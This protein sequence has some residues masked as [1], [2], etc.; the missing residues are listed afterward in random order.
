MNRL[1]LLPRIGQAITGFAYA[2]VIT[3]IVLEIFGYGFIKGAD[4]WITV[5]TMENISFQKEM[6]KSSA[7]GP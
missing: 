6:M 5:D 3:S 7:P 1:L 2:F 4:G